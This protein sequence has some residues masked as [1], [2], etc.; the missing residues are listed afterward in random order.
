MRITLNLIILFASIVLVFGQQN[1]P[2]TMVP[3]RL[4][5]IKKAT[6]QVIID[7]QP[8][9][10]GF[11]INNSGLLVTNMH[12]IE[13]ENLRVDTATNEILSKIEV[14]LNSGAIRLSYWQIL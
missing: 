3:A 10:T 4:E 12:V 6:V 14:K 1:L 7:S 11:F 5:N 13:T 9:G 2:I 8:S